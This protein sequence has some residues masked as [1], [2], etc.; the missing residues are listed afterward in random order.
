[1]GME[2]FL[3]EFAY[4]TLRHAMAG[5]GNARPIRAR[6]VPQIAK[7]LGPSMSAMAL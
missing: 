7:A 4:S 5:S 2:T 3:Q 6:L 1:M